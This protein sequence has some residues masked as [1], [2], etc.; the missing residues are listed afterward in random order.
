MRVDRPGPCGPATS[1]FRSGRR[2]PRA[3]RPHRDRRRKGSSTWSARQARP[4]LRLGR[5]ERSTRSGMAGSRSIR[6]NRRSRSQLSGR[7]RRASAKHR[8]RQADQDVWT[9]GPV[10]P[11]ESGP[12]RRAAPPPPDISSRQRDQHRRRRRAGDVRRRGQREPRQE[13]R[14]LELSVRSY[15]CLKNANM[16]PAAEC[17]DQDRGGHAQD[18]NFG[19]KSLNEIKRF[20]PAWAEPAALRPGGSAGVGVA[21]QRVLSETSSRPS[22]AR[23]RHRAPHLAAAQQATRCCGTSTCETTVPKAPR[24]A[25]SSSA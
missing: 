8:L 12:W 23:P 13:R 14:E 2:D 20:S 17:R 5:Q 6:S 24:C 21:R 11:T 22:Q 10:S 4:R 9:N 16:P 19:R 7:G 15:N 25:R 18:Q 1:R 3:E